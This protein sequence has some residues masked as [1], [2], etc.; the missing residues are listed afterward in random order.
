MPARRDMQLPGS[1]RHF[2]PRQRSCVTS[3]ATTSADTENGFVRPARPSLRGFFSLF[4]VYASWA[5]ATH[6]ADAQKLISYRPLKSRV[7]SCFRVHPK[8]RWKRVPNPFFSTL[9]LNIFPRNS[10]LSLWW[11]PWCKPNGGHCSELVRQIS[12]VRP[13]SYTGQ[14]SFRSRCRYGGS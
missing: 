4:R 1:L 6:S 7:D 9:L 11:C 2:L 10:S 8:I 3:A 12:E 5:L 14:S 13:G